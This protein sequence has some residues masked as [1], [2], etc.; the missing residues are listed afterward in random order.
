MIP[1]M[2]QSVDHSFEDIELNLVKFP[3]IVISYTSGIMKNTDMNDRKGIFLDFT[4]KY[5]QLVQ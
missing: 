4:E 5:L 1:W 3:S 2:N